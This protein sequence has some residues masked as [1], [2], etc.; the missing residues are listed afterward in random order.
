MR[1]WKFKIDIKQHFVDK[2]VTAQVAAQGVL[3][4]LG[5]LTRRKAFKDDDELLGITQEFERLGEDTDAETQEF[6]EALE[7]L[8]DWADTN[9]VWLGL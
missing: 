8:Y 2:Q 7:R 5:K 1:D 6:D 9:D 4:E 3:K